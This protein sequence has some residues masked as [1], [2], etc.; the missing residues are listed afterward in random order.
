MNK[1]IGFIQGRLSPL[2]NGRIQAFPKDH[3]RDEFLLGDKHDI[4][5]IE[6]TLDYK[7]LH[8]N[9]LLTSEGQQ[10]IKRMSSE[11][12]ISIPS[13]TGDCFM[14]TPFWKVSKAQRESSERDFLAVVDACSIMGTKYIVVPLVDNG[15]LETTQE[16]E[17]LVEFMER[18][19]EVFQLK[20]V[21]IVFES[22]FDPPELKRFIAQFPTGIFGINYDIGNSAS[23]GYLF[24]DEFEAYGDR[25]LNVHLKDRLLGGLTVPLGAGN[26]RLPE[27]ITALE[28]GGYCGNYI[29]QTARAVDG[30]HVG[31]ICDYRDMVKDWI[32]Q[33]RWN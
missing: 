5:M 27:A 3:W 24:E 2:V 7:G 33:A 15:G 8:E 28:Q 25:I 6:W 20:E 22:D 17:V 1:R 11:N 26:A 21:V 23:L 9:P 30:D 13:L 4:R 31:A 16:E 29:L 18:H 19:T 32:G 12:S 14:Q 10:E